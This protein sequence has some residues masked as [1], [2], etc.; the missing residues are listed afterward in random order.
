MAEPKILRRF[1]KVFFLTNE[2]TN[3]ITLMFILTPDID[4]FAKSHDPEVIVSGREK[5]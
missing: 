2:C 5:T 3:K 1:F 4:V